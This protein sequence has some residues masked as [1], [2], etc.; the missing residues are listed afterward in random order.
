MCCASGQRK[1]GNQQD[2]SL[3]IPSPRLP[4]SEP[5]RLV[6]RGHGEGAPHLFGRT[7]SFIRW[8]ARHERTR[9]QHVIVH[10]SQVTKPFCD[11]W[12][13]R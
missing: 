7:A 1:Y 2:R 5:G 12:A 4:G 8:A 13:L 10:R 3:H 6:T 11:E 9:D